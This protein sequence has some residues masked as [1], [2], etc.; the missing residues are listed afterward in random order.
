MNR[1]LEIVKRRR[2]LM[3]EERWTLGRLRVRNSQVG[4]G[5]STRN[6]RFLNPRRIAEFR[7]SARCRLLSTKDSPLQKE[8]LPSSPT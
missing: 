7:N 4:I 3:L 2:R 5:W 6:V 1:A 8:K